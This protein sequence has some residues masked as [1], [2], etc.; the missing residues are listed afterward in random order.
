MKARGL[1]WKRYWP[2][3]L[4]ALPGLAYL[5]LNNYLPMA[6]L[7]VAFKKVNFKVGILASEWSG[8]E[9][10][11]FLFATKDAWLI[12][13]NTV[14]YNLAF[15]VVN[16]VCCVGLAILLNEVRS[17]R[18]KSFFQSTML[19][20]YLMSFV[21]ISYIVFAFLSPSAGFINQSVLKPLGAKSVQWYTEKGVWPYLLVFL[22]QW[23]QMGFLVVIYLSAI[24]GID[25]ALY[26]ASG[27]DGATRWQQIRYVTLPGIK[28]V[29]MMMIMLTISRM[30]YS[31]F[32]LFYQVPMDSG[33][34]YSVTNV[35]DTYVY[36]A[37]LKLGNIGMSSA[38]GFFQSMV[39]FALVL[40][41][42]L[43]IRKFDPEDALF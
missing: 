5:L 40:V 8:F 38:A 6:G 36:R 26:E 31:D 19:V 29:V 16:T 10:F 22:Q 37:L 28:S 39:G 43:A 27:I 2:L 9:N 24:I 15:L 1:Q 20:P 4:M 17:R 12:I 14:L 30:F 13:R 25:P 42:N 33:M 3:Y 11:R 41:A 23:K 7:V 34:L 21:I 32:G 35:L 18:A